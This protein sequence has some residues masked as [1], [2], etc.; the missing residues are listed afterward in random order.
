M[1]KFEWIDYYK[2]LERYKIVYVMMTNL[3]FQAFSASSHPIIA[4]IIFE[5]NEYGVHHS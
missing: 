3:F 1:N 2:V 4:L 5:E